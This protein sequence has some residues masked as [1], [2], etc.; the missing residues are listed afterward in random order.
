M[1]SECCCNLKVQTSDLKLY[2]AAEVIRSQHYVLAFF[3]QVPKSDPILFYILILRT[4]TKVVR[5]KKVLALCL[6]LTTLVEQWPQVYCVRITFEL[7]PNNWFAST[8]TNSMKCH[9]KWITVNTHV[10]SNKT[11]PCLDVTDDDWFYYF[12]P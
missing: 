3:L 12:Q 8:R 6:L 10:C 9:I 1:Q 11:Q 5:K 7:L 4:Y 2:L